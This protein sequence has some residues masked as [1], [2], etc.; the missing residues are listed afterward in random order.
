MRPSRLLTSSSFHLKIAPQIGLSTLLT[1][2][3]LAA[4]S[5]SYLMQKSSTQYVNLFI[6]IGITQEVYCSFQTSLLSSNQKL[7]EEILWEFAL[8]SM[9]LEELAAP[10]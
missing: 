10:S 9:D 6:A 5:K 2:K 3:W 1:I 4:V 8:V 7:N